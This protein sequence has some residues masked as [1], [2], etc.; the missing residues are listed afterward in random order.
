MHEVLS[1]SPYHNHTHIRVVR[2]LMRKIY[3]EVLAA[4]LQNSIHDSWK[5][6]PVKD[7][8]VVRLDISALV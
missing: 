4:K 2:L 7:I 1:V 6:R 8:I 3:M 5:K